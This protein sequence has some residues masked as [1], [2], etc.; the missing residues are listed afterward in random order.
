M[1]AVLR[2]GTRGSPLALAQAAEAQARLA[3]RHPELADAIAIVPIRTSGDRPSQK[4]LAEEGGKG[5]FTKEIEEA[6]LSGAIDIAVHSMKDMPTVSQPGLAISCCLPREDPRDAFVSTSAGRIAELAPRAIVGTASVR[7]R[8]QLLH[9]RPDLVVVPLR[10][11]VGT[12]LRKLAAGEF[13][14][15]LLAVAGLKRLGRADCIASIVA[16]EEMLP[17]AG[18]GIIALETR[19][20]DAKARAWLAAIDDAATAICATAERALLAALDGSCQTPIAALATVKD[21][22]VALDAMVISRDGGALY[23]TRREG[24]A[25]EAQ[26]LG[27]DAGAE[28]RARADPDIFA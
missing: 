16:P 15:T 22:R 5:L 19:A 20:D 24:G 9:L 27:A 17:A 6:L 14:A 8:A 11:N 12:R 23:R 1:K 13:A 4:S 7:R 2:L 25:G 21:G 10:G 28:L 3:A 26:A 18:Q